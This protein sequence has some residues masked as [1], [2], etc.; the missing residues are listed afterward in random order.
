MVSSLK[1]QA[2]KILKRMENIPA[3]AGMTLRSIDNPPTLVNYICGNFGV[4]IADKQKL[5]EMSSLKERAINLLEILTSELQMLDMKEVIKSKTKE[6]MDKEQREY[7][8]Q[9]QMETIQR[10]LGNTDEQMANAMLERAKQKKWSEK[11]QTTFE[12]ELK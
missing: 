4:R 6:D 5:L 1:G 3:E 9:R 11:M 8:L 2:E 7:Y 12:Y 10:E